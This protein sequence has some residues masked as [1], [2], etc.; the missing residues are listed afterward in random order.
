MAFF[1]PHFSW[2]FYWLIIPLFLDLVASL[3]SL[4]YSALFCDFF[5]N[6]SFPVSI[7]ELPFLL[8]LLV[9]VYTSDFT[10]PSLILPLILKEFI[11]SQGCSYYHQAENFH[12]YTSRT[13]SWEL[14]PV[15]FHLL[16]PCCW[17]F[18]HL[19]ELNITKSQR[20]PFPTKP[21]RPN[22]HTGPKP[23]RHPSFLCKY[24]HTKT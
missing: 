17:I 4:T 18:C 11:H 9:F 5:A 6:H 22:D 10:S 13:F 16:H 8:W 23:G 2:P 12:T 1:S 21:P 7:R 15:S 20:A 14:I 19:L 24:V 3:V